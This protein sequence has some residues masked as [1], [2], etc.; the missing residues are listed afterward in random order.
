MENKFIFLVVLC[1]T[2]HIIRT[3]YEILKRGNKIKAGRTSFIIIFADMVVL[4]VSWFMLCGADTNILLI[5]SPV[6]YAGMAV[7]AAGSLLFLTALL[8]IRTLET[9][10]GDLVTSGIYSKIRHPM[11]LG[12]IFWLVGFPVFC[13]SYYSMILAIPFIFN[14]LYWRRL[15]ELELSERFYDYE[16]YRRRTWF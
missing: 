1:I 7:T 10:E 8:T 12:F 13:G 5:P 9:Y 3:V 14:V 11:Y 4:W 2:A 15:E 16:E 6:K